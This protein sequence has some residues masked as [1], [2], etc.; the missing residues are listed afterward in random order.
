MP[1][2]QACVRKMSSQ[3]SR[4]YWKTKD[5]NLLVFWS[6]PPG[7]HKP[8][9][10]HGQPQ[11]EVFHI[12]QVFCITVESVTLP[13]SSYWTGNPI[14]ATIRNWTIRVLQ[15]VLQLLGPSMCDWHFLLLA[16]IYK[17]TSCNN[18]SPKLLIIP[19]NKRDS[20]GETESQRNVTAYS[21]G[22]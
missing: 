3:N 4:C 16:T 11:L 13:L 9:Y 21:W 20:G 18:H 15:D 6:L 8:Q 7:V 17:Q 12:H 10:R 14:T 5:W 22:K 1:A 19:R 2:S